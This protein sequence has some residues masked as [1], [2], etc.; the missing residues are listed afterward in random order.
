MLCGGSCLNW[1]P[2]LV[3]ARSGSQ[4]RS[5]RQSLPNWQLFLFTF[6]LG[7]EL[8]IPYLVLRNLIKLRKIHQYL[9]Q[10]LQFMCM[11]DCSSDLRSRNRT[12]Q[13][14]VKF[15]IC[16]IASEQSSP[17]A[18]VEFPMEGHGAAMVVVAGRVAQ[19]AQVRTWS[20]CGQSPSKPPT[21]LPTNTYKYNKVEH[22]VILSSCLGKAL[23]VNSVGH[24]TQCLLKV[25]H[26]PNHTMQCRD[27]SR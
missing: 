19:V 15:I 26:R 5:K 12:R 4:G 23:V 7:V 24:V 8:L 6:N 21:H 10:Q 27:G 11:K 18:G 16:N 17:I 3:T 25:C 9:A 20:D 1:S 22:K 14:I 2:D 13:L